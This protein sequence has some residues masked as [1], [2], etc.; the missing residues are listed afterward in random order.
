MKKKFYTRE[1]LKR[2]G[3]RQLIRTDH[4]TYHYY[5]FL[6]HDERNRFPVDEIKFEDVDDFILS[7]KCRI[8]KLEG[9]LINAICFLNY[10]EAVNHFYENLTEEQRKQYLLHEGNI[11]QKAVLNEE[12]IKA[13]NEQLT[14]KHQSNGRNS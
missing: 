4:D 13:L 14:I 8:S 1:D 10:P 7:V 6:L 9:A 3:Q 12:K 2:K 5:D 11:F